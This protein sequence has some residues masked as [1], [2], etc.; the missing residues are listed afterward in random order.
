MALPHL[1]QAGVAELREFRGA[2]ASY[3][4]QAFLEKVGPIN[5]AEASHTWPPGGVPGKLS[6]RTGQTPGYSRLLSRDPVLPWL[7]AHGRLS[8]AASGSPWC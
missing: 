1:E 3:D 4:R 8:C 6:L 5:R 7:R 2:L